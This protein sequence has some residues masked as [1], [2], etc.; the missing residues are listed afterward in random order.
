M[1]DIIIVAIVIIIIMI[2]IY[3]YLCQQVSLSRILN[4]FK[5]NMSLLIRLWE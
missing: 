1:L 4:Y 5:I 2:N 3:I